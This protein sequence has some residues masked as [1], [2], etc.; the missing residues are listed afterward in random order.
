MSAVIRFEPVAYCADCVDG[1]DWDAEPEE[2]AKKHNT[3]HHEG[4][5]E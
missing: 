5:T 3:E 1:A 2:W 4:A